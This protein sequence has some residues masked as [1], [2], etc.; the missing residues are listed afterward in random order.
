MELN[1]RS[2]ATEEKKSN[3]KFCTGFHFDHFEI[4]KKKWKTIVPKDSQEK[5]VPQRDKELGYIIHHWIL[6]WILD[7][8]KNEI[9]LLT[10]SVELNSISLHARFPSADF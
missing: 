1:G 3:L 9:V 2:Q 7:K 4:Q 5:T 10:K 8:H 6:F